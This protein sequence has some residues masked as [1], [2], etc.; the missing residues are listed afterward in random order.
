MDSPTSDTTCSGVVA[1]N[2]GLVTHPYIPH[3]TGYG[4]AVT[5][6]ATI[7]VLELLGHRVTV[8]HIAGRNEPAAFAALANRGITTSVIPWDGGGP[9]PFGTA[10]VL[11]VVQR[12]LAQQSP[13]AA[14]PRLDMLYAYGPYAAAPVALMTIP[15]VATVVD[16][17]HLVPW[18]RRMFDLRQPLSP[19]MAACSIDTM[20]KRSEALVT[21][22]RPFDQMFDH[23]AHHAGWLQKQGLACDYLPMPVADTPDVSRATRT[24]DVLML[25][26]YRGVATLSGL[27]FFAEQVLPWLPDSIAVRICGADEMPPELE[28]AFTHYPQVSIMGYVEDIA[29][30]LDRAGVVLVPTP[31]PLGLRTRIVEAFAHRTPVVAHVANRDGMPELMNKENCLL[32]TDGRE[33]AE[34]IMSALSLATGRRLG[35]AGRAI[36]ESHF[37]I[38]AVA[39]YLGP[40]LQ[41]V[42]GEKVAA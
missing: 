9:Q 20:V 8:I 39:R 32:A 42:V 33:L 25:G 34:Q 29:G 19:V 41:R 2:I 30:E 28:R 24:R 35:E 4:V 27:Y 18:Y 38:P 17:D 13:F 14:F 22:L 6:W 36:Y 31:I 10:S 40:Y 16:L 23:A 3:P 15:K 5:L 1:V 11:P 21:M 26:H 37:S 7:D 12:I